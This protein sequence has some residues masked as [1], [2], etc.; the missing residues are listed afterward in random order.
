[1][2]YFKYILFAMLL[3]GTGMLSSCSDDAE[4]VLLQLFD[5][6]MKV[7]AISP[8]KGYVGG[9]FA[10]T[11]SNFG[12]SDQLI[13]VKIGSTDCS[14][15]SCSDERIV[16]RVPEGVTSGIVSVSLKND[17][18][19]TTDSTFTVVTPN[20]T[21]ASEK[22]FRGDT[23]KVTGTNMPTKIGKSDLTAYFGKT[24]A[25]VGKYTADA[26]G[27]ATIS[28]VVPTTLAVG[29]SSLRLQL[30]GYDIF[31]KDINILEAPVIESLD[32]KVITS[33]TMT[34]SG[35]GFSDF[36]DNVTV[37]FGSEAVKA[38]V[39]SD[40]QLS[41]NVPSSYTGGEVKIS[42]GSCMPAIS[43][44]TPTLLPTGEVTSYFLK[45][46]ATPMDYDTDGTLNRGWI[47]PTD[48]TVNGT[49]TGLGYK[50]A[51]KVFGAEALA[52]TYPQNA[53]MYQVATLPAG[54]YTLTVT[55][56]KVTNTKGR[57]GTLL[58]VT[59]GNGTLP[60]LTDKSATTG[61]SGW[62]YSKDD[63]SSVI[64]AKRITDTKTT[65]TAKQTLEFTLDKETEVTIGF[66]FQV[67]GDGK[68][69][70]SALRLDRK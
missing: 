56:E 45:N 63:A 70:M 4:N 18:T 22:A 26:A 61:V 25:T 5:S 60:D 21:A 31:T 50:P 51:E 28:I 37:Y 32:G 38:T 15:V 67:N 2:K 57:F 27:N 46:T 66:V 6:P 17:T 39:I 29:T 64:A 33:G 10:I 68:V 58:M 24:Q 69:L 36:G 35:K 48:W 8:T 55:T 41:V 3:P 14:I 30:Y 23:L 12:A 53:K 54:T 49:Y 20:L 34:L 7:T 59:S 9:T 11:G 13:Q 47:T 40:T 44:G 42:F 19:L 43:L 16:A 62:W 65:S 52:Q 1:M